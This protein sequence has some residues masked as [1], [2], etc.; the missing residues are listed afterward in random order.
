MQKL[1]SIFRKHPAISTD[2]R[3]ISQGSIFFSLK[4]PSFNGNEFAESALEKGA[5]F[6]V[7]DQEE[8]KKDERFILVGDCLKT[9]QHLALHHRRTLKIPVLA[10]TGS[11]GK[12]TTKELVKS[13]LAEK[14]RTLA[15]KGNL[16]NHIG[17]PLTILSIGDDTEFAVI[18]MGANHQKEIESYCLI[19]EP[20]YGL[21]TNVG[22]A[23]L[24]GFGG[25]EGVKKGKGEL[26]RWIHESGKMI[27]RNENNSHLKE[28]SSYMSKEKIYGYGTDSSCSTQGKLTGIQPF[29]SIEWKC[30]DQ[31]GKFDSQIIGEYNFEN[32]LAAIAIGNYFGVE[33]D[34]I[35]H[36]IA[37]YSPDNS[38]SQ[39]IRKEKN[40]I[41]L[42]A[43]NANP[44]SM[45]AALK[46]FE[47][48]D[49]AQKVICIGD[50]AELGE[51]SER[52]HEKIIQL[53]K[54]IRHELLLLVGPQFGN[55]KNQI[56]CVHFQ[57]STSAAQWLK[58][59]ALHGK[60]FLI[61]GSRSSKM[62]LLASAID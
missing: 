1:Y 46:N 34:Q 14:F 29:L 23:H 18:E 26:Y 20:D 24:E 58:D 54:K 27:F 47:S 53:L 31:R 17:V 50:M 41:I 38:R 13:V 2:S 5:A 6:A 40:T 37:S 8:F 3:N 35:K 39:I 4:G 11:N 16:N 52:E 60:T 28:M 48:L 7:I 9:L 32:I 15:T 25:F 44:T 33:P 30:G 55:F 22:K 10:I 12:T 59:Q 61:K 45:E 51:D 56:D 19:A 49:S 21:I 57:D 62:E 42:D 43:Y 36:A